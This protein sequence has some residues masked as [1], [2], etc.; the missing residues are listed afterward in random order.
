LWPFWD[1]PRP[2]D[3]AVSDSITMHAFYSRTDAKQHDVVLGEGLA[4]TFVPAREVLELDL[5]VS[6]GFLVPMFLSSE[7]YALLH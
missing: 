6:A 2:A 7:Q 5:T 4:M 3:P 1:G